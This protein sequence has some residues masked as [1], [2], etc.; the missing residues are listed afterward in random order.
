MSDHILVVDNL[1]AGYGKLVVLHDVSLAIDAKRFYAVLGPNGSGK[2]TLVKSVFGLTQI[3]DGDILFEDQS[4]TGMPTE[5]I[6]RLGLAYVPQRENIFAA[7]SVREN[8]QLAVRELGRAE[9][10]RALAEA[11]TLFPILTQREK[12]RADR[13][14]G[15][16]R[17]MLAIAMGWLTR[18][19]LM[20]LDEPSAGLAPRL[21]TEVFRTLRA[22]CEQGI[23]IVVVE[24]NARSVLRWCDYA[25]IV[26]EGRLVFEGTD[27]QVWS[28]EETVRGYLGIRARRRNPEAGA[29]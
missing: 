6:S 28:D 20:L 11:H 15:G 13:L 22:L 25:Y 2:S 5:R 29:A 24:Q 12:Q 1:S 27:E 14:S 16:E 19:T 18:P 10:E 4:I 7:M 21:V 17:Q 8:L 23:T 26:R 9:G 3:F